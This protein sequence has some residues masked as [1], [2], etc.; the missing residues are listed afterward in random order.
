MLIPGALPSIAP[1]EGALRSSRE[2]R[3]LYAFLLR[4]MR[5]VLTCRPVTLCREPLVGSAS[6]APLPYTRNFFGLSTS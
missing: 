6:L 2:M 1:L 3:Q 4:V 5:S